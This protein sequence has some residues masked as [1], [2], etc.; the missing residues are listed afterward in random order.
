MQSSCKTRDTAAGGLNRMART[1]CGTGFSQGFSLSTGIF[2]AVLTTVGG[3]SARPTPGVWARVAGDVLDG[4]LLGVAARKA[5][6]PA[7]V[8]TAAALVLPV[9]AADM[10]DAPKLSAQKMMA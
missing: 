4:V 10:I 8:I 1:R 7:G 6:N 3:A 9:V 5:T 2:L